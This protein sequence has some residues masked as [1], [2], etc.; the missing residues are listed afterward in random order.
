MGSKPRM[1]GL[2]AREESLMISLAVSIH[3][4]SVT[5]RKMDR[6]W[7]IARMATCIALCSKN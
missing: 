6:H 5:E 3:Y 7:T 2:P 4:M 1:M